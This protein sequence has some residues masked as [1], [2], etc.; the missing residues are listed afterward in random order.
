MAQNTIY[1]MPFL[2]TLSFTHLLIFIKHIFGS[3]LNPN[4]PPKREFST[5]GTLNVYLLKYTTIPWFLLPRS[6]F[7][8][9]NP[10]LLDLSY[11]QTFDVDKVKHSVN[12]H[13]IYLQ[14]AFSVHDDFY[15]YLHYA[16]TTTTNHN[17]SFTFLYRPLP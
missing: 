4:S 17:R 2:S 16:D 1:F 7:G 8:K 11:F 5:V 15:V 14:M 13:D 12:C 10:L 6:F 3:A 9:I